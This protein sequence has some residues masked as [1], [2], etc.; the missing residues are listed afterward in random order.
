MKKFWNNNKSLILIMTVVLLIIASTVV[1][2]G[3]PEKAKH[4]ILSNQRIVVEIPTPRSVEKISVGDGRMAVSTGEKIALQSNERVVIDGGKT[5]KEGYV[6]AEGAA[7]AWAPD[8]K[9]VYVRSLGTVTVDG[10]SSG[11]EVVFGSKTQ[12]KGYVVAVIGGAIA[13]RGE[14]VLP[15]SGHATPENWYDAKEAIKSIQALPLFKDA[16]I[17]GINLYFDGKIWEYVIASSK[18]TV[19]VPVR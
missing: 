7:T 17:S 15:D 19:S 13:S 3:S 16:T 14:S 8:A 9:L 10:V 5:L 12:E 1:Y 18:G 6:I 11:W 4:A 2:Y